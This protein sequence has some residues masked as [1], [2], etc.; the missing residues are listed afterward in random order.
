MPSSAPSI[1]RS[2]RLVFGKGRD[3]DPK[4]AGLRRGA[5]G[6]RNPD[7]AQ[8]VLNPCRE[9]FDDKGGGRAGAEAENH[10]VLDLFDRAQCRCAL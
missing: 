5:L 8:P 1:V 3:R 9:P 10:A 7:N 2:S 4:P 6:G